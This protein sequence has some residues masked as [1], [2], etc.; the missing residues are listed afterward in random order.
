MNIE[1]VKLAL[2]VYDAIMKIFDITW[3]DYKESPE[4]RSSFLHL[5]TYA[6]IEHDKVLLS[7]KDKVT[8]F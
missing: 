6:I 4:K 3:G 1:R 8:I 7:Q 5:K 2:D